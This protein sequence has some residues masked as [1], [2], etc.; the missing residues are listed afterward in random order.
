MPRDLESQWSTRSGER[1]DSGGRSELDLNPGNITH[2]QCG[3]LQGL[4]LTKPQF[5]HLH[6]EDNDSY[7]I[8]DTMQARCWHMPHTP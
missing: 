7:L 2:Q 3:L 5:H 6:N 8:H 4:D 1:M